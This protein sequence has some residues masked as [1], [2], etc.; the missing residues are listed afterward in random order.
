MGIG[1]NLIALFAMHYTC[2]FFFGEGFFLRAG[3][4]VYG[5]IAFLLLLSVR[6]TV[7]TVYDYLVVHNGQVVPVVV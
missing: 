4:L 5:V 3:I 6:L 1:S 2:Y 7:K